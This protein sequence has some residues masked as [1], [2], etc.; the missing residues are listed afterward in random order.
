[1]VAP[2]SIVEGGGGVGPSELDSKAAEFLRM[3]VREEF[4][5][6]EATDKHVFPV[7]GGYWGVPFGS[8]KGLNGFCHLV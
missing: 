8:D 2:A 3:S 7:F 1:M 6:F 5:F 4:F